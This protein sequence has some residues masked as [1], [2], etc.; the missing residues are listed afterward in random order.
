MALRGGTP[1]RTVH[2]SRS[3]D[4]PAR[5]PACEAPAP[6]PPTAVGRDGRRERPARSPGRGRGRVRRLR[7]RARLHT[8]RDR[9]S[10]TIPDSS[11][12]RSGPVCSSAPRCPQGWPGRGCSSGPDSNALRHA[13]AAR[14]L[15]AALLA[16]GS[17]LVS[18]EGPTGSSAARTFALLWAGSTG[19]VEPSPVRPPRPGS[20]SRA[21]SARSGWSRACGVRPSRARR[22]GLRPCT[23][24]VV[25][26]IALAQA[27]GADASRTARPLRNPPGRPNSR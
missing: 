21:A 2:P 11:T 25:A 3:A 8:Q 5:R 18:P 19:L 26:A 4:S 1:R 24:T 22:S 20:R 6:R 10:D 13:E 17:V 12:A 9:G 27:L 15:L 16:L 23:G 14:P 7:W